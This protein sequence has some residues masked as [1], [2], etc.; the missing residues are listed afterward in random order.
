MKN[1][2]RKKKLHPA[3]K[4]KTLKLFSRIFRNTI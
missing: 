3:Q 2:S 4:N 1:L